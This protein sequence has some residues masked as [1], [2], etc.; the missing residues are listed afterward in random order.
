MTRFEVERMIDFLIFREKLINYRFVLFYN[1]KN[2]NEI[3]R[4]MNDKETI[5]TKENDESSG[6]YL[7]ITKIFT[8]K[9]IFLQNYFNVENISHELL[10]VIISNIPLKIDKK[11]N[12]LIIQYERDN[13]R[14]TN[15]YH[16]HNK[17]K[18]IKRHKMLNVDYDLCDNTYK[19]LLKRQVESLELTNNSDA[20]IDF[21]GFVDLFFK[22]PFIVDSI[23]SIISHS[24]SFNKQSNKILF[25]LVKFALISS[26]YDTIFLFVFS[27]NVINQL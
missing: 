20:E 12:Q 9:V 10:Q 3:I 5:I 16:Y 18:S 24:F 15:T 17:S 26:N 1:K 6:L 11:F 2:Q 4:M 22:L 23:R 13:I 19:F 8:Q 21:E 27:K 25:P 7:N 14:I